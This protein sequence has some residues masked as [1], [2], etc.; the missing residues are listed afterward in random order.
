MIS[1]S[2]ASARLKW[3]NLVNSWSLLWVIERR[4][5]TYDAFL[6]VR[7]S[8]RYSLYSSMISFTFGF[9]GKDTSCFDRKVEISVVLRPVQFVL[10]PYLVVFRDRFPIVHQLNAKDIWDWY[11]HFR[12]F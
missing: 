7:F 4:T 3:K 12:S 11:L 8:F 10:Q 5:A 2:K 9:R 6:S 1:S